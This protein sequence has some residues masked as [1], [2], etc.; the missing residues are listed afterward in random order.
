MAL[1]NQSNRLHGSIKTTKDFGG[2]I[3]PVPCFYNAF[4]ER[5][6]EH[7]KWFNIQYEQ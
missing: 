3:T 7:F 4:L 5:E 6:G 2:F 1:L